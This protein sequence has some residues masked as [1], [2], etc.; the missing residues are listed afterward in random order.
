[1]MVR[2]QPILVL[3][4]TISFLAATLCAI[5]ATRAQRPRKAKADAAAVKARPFVSAN[6]TRA[7]RGN[8]EEARL[9]ELDQIERFHLAEAGVASAIWRAIEPTLSVNQAPESLLRAIRIYGLFD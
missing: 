2:R 9:R 5:Q 8:S 4:G 1:M 7:F 3:L 6:L